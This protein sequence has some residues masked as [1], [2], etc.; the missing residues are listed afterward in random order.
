[1]SIT[2]S[3]RP[4]ALKRR[5]TPSR[6]EK[7]T[8]G[9]YLLKRL[10]SL[11]LSHF[12]VTPHADLTSLS[13]TIEQHSKIT[14]VANPSI[15]SCGEMADGYGKA[16]GISAIAVQ[17][18]GPKALDILMRAYSESVPQVVVF[19]KNNL[20]PHSID[21]GT[22]IFEKLLRQHSASWTELSDPLLAAKKIDRALDYCVFFKKPVCIELP[23]EVVDCF[24]P[25][26]IYH[27]MEFGISDPDT[28]DE[29]LLELESLFNKAKHALIHLDRDV[30]AHKAES[31][32]LHFAERWHIPVTSSNTAKNFLLESHPNYCGSL[33]EE[34]VAR[35]DLVC[36]IGKEHIP[37]QHKGHNI[38]I[39]AQHAYIDNR[40]YPQLL[41]KEVLL[42][43]CALEPHKHRKL[44]QARTCP[45][46]LLEH[47]VITCRDKELLDD[48]WPYFTRDVI[49]SN[50]ASPHY[51]LAAA[52][53][54][55]KALPRKRPI[56]LL[57][58]TDLKSSLTELYIAHEE[59]LPLLICVAGNGSWIK[60]LFPDIPVYRRRIPDT[61]PYE[62][63]IIS[64][65]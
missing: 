55:A 27:P 9:Q 46:S 10:S 28:L 34:L 42:A 49:A 45:D 51:S 2:A 22:S 33:T 20:L 39:G 60:G 19:G 16:R 23:D 3:G 8:V 64:L 13:R 40:E 50:L 37:L 25:E 59:C 44:W 56:V 21:E 6:S 7:L 1:M 35:A 26:H 11:T 62:L 53:G 4:R 5:K 18:H 14:L 32:L 48:M 24:I 15:E 36:V 41:V 52:I 57:D 43:L 63:V 47:V 58:E 12:F 30:V 17:G 65:E 54:A 31:L 29:L 38:L 61:L